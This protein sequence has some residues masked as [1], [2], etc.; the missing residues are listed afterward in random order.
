M[1]GY[2][3]RCIRFSCLS[4]IFRCKVSRAFCEWLGIKERSLQYVLD[5][6]RNR[7]LWK[8]DSEVD[9]KSKSNTD[10]HKEFPGKNKFIENSSLKEMLMM[11]ILRLGRAILRLINKDNLYLILLNMVQL[12]S[13][14][15]TK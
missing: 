11:N 13:N 2:Q 4:S 12:A 3:K 9:S 10:I 8:Q 14:V 1:E 5:M 6:H 7:N 15:K